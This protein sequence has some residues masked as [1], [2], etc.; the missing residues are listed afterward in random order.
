MNQIKAFLISY[1]KTIFLVLGLVTLLGVFFAV[2]ANQQKRA[3]QGEMTQTVILE[4]GPIAVFVEA[5]G[6]VNSNQSAVLTWETS[7]EIETVV[8]ALGQYAAAGDVL[9]SLVQSSLPPYSIMAQAELISAEKALDELLESNTQ[10]AEALKAVEDAADALEDALDPS[11]V[12]AEAQLALAEKS[13][14][15]EVAQ[16]NYDILTKPAS[17]AAINQVYANKVLAEEALVDLEAKIEQFERKVRSAPARFLRDMYQKVLDGLN[18]QRHGQLARYTDMVEKYAALTSPPDA[19]DLITIKAALAS[20]QAQYS[21]A[22]R[23]WERVE[24]GISAADMAVLEAVLADAQREW[25]RIKDGPTEEDIGA[26]EARVTAAQAQLEKIALKA[27][28]DGVITQ[29]NAQPGDQVEMGKFA[30]RID[31]LS[32]LLVR[33]EVSEMAISQVEVGQDALVT[34][35][36]VFAQEYRG[37]VIDISPVGTEVQ[38]VV[39]FKVTVAIADADQAVRPGMTADVKILVDKSDDVLLVPNQAVRWLDGELVLYVLGTNPGGL[40]TA[41]PNPEEGSGMSLDGQSVTPVVITLGLKSDTFSEITS[42]NIKAGDEILI[43]L[44]NE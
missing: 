38:G 30:F 5:V 31:N 21:D 2:R 34:L 17:E 10:R 28:F 33:L 19:L 32:T 39:S 25:E 6:T 18:L 20:A 35:D 12:Q 37:Q 36:A 9:A 44:P 14:A 29:I 11:Q 43:S 40:G 13:Q 23:A 16:R 8:P 1:K 27:P 41:N 24:N 7:G 26:A 15:L 22:Q 42:G 4:R 3:D